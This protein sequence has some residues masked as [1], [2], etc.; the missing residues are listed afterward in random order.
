MVR[1]DRNIVA[2]YFSAALGNPTCSTILIFPSPR[3]I[4][5]L[6]RPREILDVF[7]SLNVN[8]DESV[9]RTVV[10]HR[11]TIIESPLFR[12][13]DVS[14]RGFRP[15]ERWAFQNRDDFHGIWVVVAHRRWSFSVDGECDQLKCTSVQN[16]GRRESTEESYR[17]PTTDDRWE[18]LVG[19]RFRLSFNEHFFLGAQNVMPCLYPYVDRKSVNRRC[20]LKRAADATTRTR[21][22]IVVLRKRQCCSVENCLCTT[23]GEK[24]VVLVLDTLISV[25]K[26]K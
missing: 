21:E 6:L 8:F 23:T 12:H 16:V 19:L 15:S 25:L 2:P 10:H 7:W 1:G 18:V 3:V 26:R 22:T 9:C 24:Y 13:A 20:V 4:T 11:L 14:V 5:R 17:R